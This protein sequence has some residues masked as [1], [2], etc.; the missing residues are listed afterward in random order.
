MRQ[1]LLR[2]WEGLPSVGEDENA[3]DIHRR[4]K[5]LAEVKKSLEVMIETG[6]LAQHQLS[7]MEKAGRLARSAVSRLNAFARN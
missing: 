4:L 6:K 2:T 5:C 1:S 3:R 7:R